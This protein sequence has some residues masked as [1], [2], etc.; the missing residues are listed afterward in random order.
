M[1]RAGFIS[2]IAS[3]LILLA[4]CSTLNRDSRSGAALQSTV[5]GKKEMTERLTGKIWLLTGIF[6]EGEYVIIPPEHGG[7]TAVYFETAETVN[8]RVN[9]K[10]ISGT[11]SLQESSAAG[12]WPFRAA[13]PAKPA[14]PPK[15]QAERFAAAFTESL[16]QA[17]YLKTG[18]DSF[19]LLDGGKKVL[20][21]F[22]YQK[23]SL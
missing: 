17:R 5:I 4:S 13:L 21:E 23:D 20:L 19:R 9:D 22:V 12:E 8:G 3:I 7:F 11:W 14:A 10:N 2:L 16:R 6:M 18:K 1:K 15:N